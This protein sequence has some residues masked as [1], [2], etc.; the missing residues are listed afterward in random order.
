M[1]T[2]NPFKMFVGCFVPNW[3]MQS[4]KYTQGA[5]LTYGKLCQ[6]SGSDGRCFP[7]KV[8][9]AK[10]LCV[11]KSSAWKY[12]QELKDGGLII[13][14]DGYFMFLQ[15]DDMDIKSFTSETKVSYRKPEVSPVKPLYNEENQ[16]RE[17]IREEQ[18]TVSKNQTPLLVTNYFFS[19][20]KERYKTNYPADRGRFIKALKNIE[21]DLPFESFKTM[22][23]KF[24]DGGGDDM[25]KFIWA[26]PKLATAVVKKP[27]VDGFARYNDPNYRLDG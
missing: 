12:V 7:K 1:Q 14:K 25:Q 11:S 8:T 2:I 13:E 10:D 22:I 4:D 23:D 3:L 5:K 9:L 19:K 26:M 16:L 21:S 6:Y 18:P 20:Y 27:I 15:S 24:I 17:S